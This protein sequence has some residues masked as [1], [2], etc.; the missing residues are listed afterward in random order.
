MKTML[1][2]G[3]MA[4]LII[5]TSITTAINAAT[6]ENVATVGQAAPDFTAKDSNGADQTLS[7][8]KGKVVVLEWTNPE[9]P[10]VKKHYSSNNMQT[11]QKAAVDA[12]AVWL[13]VNSAANADKQ[14]HWTPEAANKYAADN[15]VA[16]TATILDESGVVGKLY[17]AKTTPHM[18]VID[19]DGTLVYAG[20]IDDNDSSDADDIATSKNYVK[21]VLDDLNAGRPASVT[22]TKAYGCGVKYA[23]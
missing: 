15:N 8:Y 4:A 14:G 21:T 5:G 20:A 18:Y 7:S 3:L 6:P 12:G 19:K 22:Q 23:D 11:L 17:N 16:A 9:C 2:F 1:A 10:Y 13:R